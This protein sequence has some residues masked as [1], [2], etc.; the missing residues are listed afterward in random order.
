M[1]ERTAMGR[2]LLN[3]GL[4][5]DE[6]LQ[7]ALEAQRHEG[8]RLG[9]H[10]I[11]MGYL[12]VHRL[13]QFLKE[14][15]G[16]I[17]Y[18]LSQWITDPSVTELIPPNIARFYQ[19]VPV[20]RDGNVLT[21]AIADLDNPSIIPA[22]EELTGLTIDTVVCP[23]ETVINAL[24]R[25]YGAT[26]DPG[27]IRNVSGDHVFI[28]SLKSK[29]IRPLH[30]SSLKPD[31]S[32]SDWL[33]TALAEA[34][35]TGCRII[36]IKPDEHSLRIAF[37]TGNSVEERF[38]L[39]AGKREE[40]SALLKE[41]A[42]IG[43]RGGGRIEG[44][45]RIQ[46]DSRFLTLFVKGMAT[47]Q[48]IRY[49]LT[50]YDERVFLQ[51]WEKL[52][53]QLREEERTGLEEALS[54]DPGMVILCGPPGS[55]IYNAYYSLMSHVAPGVDPVIALEE[56]SMVSLHGVSQ[57]EV[58][59]EEGASWSELITLALKQDPR[60]FSCFPVKERDSMELNLLAASHTRVISVIHQPDATSTLRWLW[61]NRFRSPLRAGVIK[62]ILTVVSVPTLCPACQLPVE[63]NGSEG[64]PYHLFTRQGCENC[65]T[66]ETLPTTEFLEW[67][68]LGRKSSL[69]FKDCPTLEGTHKWIEEQGGITLE[70]RVL[71]AASEGLVDGY[72]AADLLP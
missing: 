23:R 51:R 6:Q 7:S 1:P 31:S 29:K 72:E 50:L 8:G 39:D 68:R 61:R 57:M 34:I 65:L 25:F 10:L 16:L 32:A 22:I 2:L 13:S 40:M 5:T 56:F 63:V 20:E 14:S 12:D 26:K 60:L 11:K 24:E 19:V 21:V 17:P 59:R 48:G 45:I 69:L 70:K 66:W 38:G 64:G 18:D 49:T 15:M 27:V 33:R 36:Y 52:T 30:W 47:I 28:L 41:L 35:R 42:S 71:Q 53:D 3:E 55:G 4:L 46:V 37:R 62:G 43:D 58:A 9:Y 54:R 67:L 44:R